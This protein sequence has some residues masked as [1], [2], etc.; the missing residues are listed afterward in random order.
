[1]LEYSN[2]V[3]L[4]TYPPT[5]MEQTV[6]GNI[7]TKNSD[8]VELPRRKRTKF[9]TRRKFEIKKEIISLNDI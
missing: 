2:L 4:H 1:M 7:G 9:R 5:K 8:A 6:F 3:V